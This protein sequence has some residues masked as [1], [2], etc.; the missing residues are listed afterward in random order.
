MKKSFVLFMILLIFML[1][2]AKVV[3]AQ[4]VCP[5]SEGW[6]TL[7]IPTELENKWGTL[8]FQINGSLEQ[9]CIQ[10]TIYTGEMP[11]DG[12]ATIRGFG[13]GT[14]EIDRGDGEF[15]EVSYLVKASP[16]ATSTSTIT[17]VITN[18]PTVTET[19]VATATTIYTKTPSNTAIP[20]SAS[21]QQSFIQ[22]I[23]E[24]TGKWFYFAIAAVLI[25]VLA[26]VL[27][28]KRKR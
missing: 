16:T 12:K 21:T 19:P 6:E 14:V 10:G 7:T 20:L 18:T 1:I 4:D 9:V 26:I 8:A 28:T 3:S 15:Y 2:P 22:K 25:A 11:S 5:K 17:P 23:E 13:L 27:I 24:T